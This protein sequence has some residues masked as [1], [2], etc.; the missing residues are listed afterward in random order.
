[1]GGAEVVVSCASG[2]DVGSGIAFLDR[3]AYILENAIRLP[4]CVDRRGIVVIHSVDGWARHV[5]AVF[6]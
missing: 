4:G 5:G 2:H 1:M 3:G 6:C